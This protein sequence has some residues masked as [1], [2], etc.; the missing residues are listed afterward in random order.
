VAVHA[1]QAALGVTVKV[2]GTSGVTPQLGWRELLGHVSTVDVP[3]AGRLAAEVT[4]IEHG[5]MTKLAVTLWAAFMAMD[6]GFA[7]P[8]RSPVQLLN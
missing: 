1:P 8:L 3:V 2:T 4:L 5:G 6:W 7:L